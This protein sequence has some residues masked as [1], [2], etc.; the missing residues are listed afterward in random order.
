[1]NPSHRDQ[2]YRD[3]MHE[4]TD[5]YFSGLKGSPI[6][7]NLDYDNGNKYDALIRGWTKYW[8][9]TL[10]D[11]EPLDP[12]L[13]KALIATESSFNPKKTNR[14]KGKHQAIGLMQVTNETRKILANEKGELKDRLV[15]VTDKDA[16]DPTLNIAAGTRWLFQ[17]KRLASIKL[18]RRATWEEGVAEYKS[19]LKE[20]IEFKNNPEGKKPTKKQESAGRQM[21]KFLGLYE[22]LKR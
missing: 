2:L 7:D 20:W 13:V 16:F 12:N 21:K 8:N 9:E 18:K 4:I 17:K 10:E 6:N 22:R 11:E 15:N 19:Y 5:K 3:E 1:M 14:V